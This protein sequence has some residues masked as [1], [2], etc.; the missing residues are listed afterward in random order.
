MRCFDKR[1]QLTVFIMIGLILLV[2]FGLIL[3]AQKKG[4]ENDPEV[5][6]ALHLP[7]KLSHLNVFFDSSSPFSV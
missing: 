5:I 7:E 2:S 3:T 1:G 6:K 4:A